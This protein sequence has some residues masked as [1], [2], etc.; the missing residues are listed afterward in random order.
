M[1]LNDNAIIVD[2]VIT[3]QHSRKTSKWDVAENEQTSIK[4]PIQK[5]KTLRAGTKLKLLK[6]ISIKKL[7]NNL[8]Y[9]S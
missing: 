8:K 5:N 3:F 9:P 4:I 2:F 1:D 7:S 6:E